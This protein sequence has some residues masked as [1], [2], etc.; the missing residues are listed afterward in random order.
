MSQELLVNG[1]CMSEYSREI[2]GWSFI[3]FIMKADGELPL[4]LVE[5]GRASWSDGWYNVSSSVFMI[6]L[7]RIAVF[8]MFTGCAV[9]IFSR[10]RCTWNGPTQLNSNLPLQI[11]GSWGHH[12]YV[13]G[14]LAVRYRWTG[15]VL[16]NKRLK[17]ETSGELQIILRESIEYS[18]NDESKTGRC[19]YVTNWIHNHYDLDRLYMPKTFLAEPYIG[20]HARPCPWVLGGH[21]CDIFVY[22]W[23]WVG[24]GAIL[25]VMLRRL[26]LWVD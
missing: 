17:F 20:C 25:L 14:E 12:T 15:W 18:S 10:V 9:L 4:P 8:F 3:S 26:P 13:Q 7:L 16:R 22:G 19:H 23:A 1:A 11:F 5:Q 24:V 6:E 2:R 21:G